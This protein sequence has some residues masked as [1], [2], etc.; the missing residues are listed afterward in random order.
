MDTRRF[1][2]FA[3]TPR[4]ARYAA[5]ALG[6][7]LLV[8]VAAAERPRELPAREHLAV[9]APADALQ[10]IAR[11]GKRLVAVGSKGLVLESIDGGQR[12]ER[13]E[14]PGRPPFIALTVCPDGRFLLLDFRSGLWGRSSRDAP[15]ERRPIQNDP[16]N[17]PAGARLL[18]L[19][20]GPTGDLWAVGEYSTVLR[21]DD[22]GNRWRRVFDDRSDR[23]LTAV[24]L[25]GVD[26]VRVVGEFGTFLATDDGGKEWRIGPSVEGD[27][28]PH[29]AAFAPDG[30]TWV[31]GNTGAV[32]RLDAGA[33]QWVQEETQFSGAVYGISRG[34]GAMVIVGAGGFA[35]RRQEGTPPRWKRLLASPRRGVAHDLRG[36]TR[37]AEGPL[38]A[39][40]SAGLVRLNASSADAGSS[41]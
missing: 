2:R 5:I 19:H 12:F 41:P 23:L 37:P 30:R 6:S 16:E 36:L 27:L 40:G 39:V 31:V 38:F 20:C 11:D 13:T 25:I 1:C 22:R 28:Y 15:W 3:R 21:S 10:A 33:E 14:L 24:G 4:G 29:A 18:D 7:V 17:R 8:T 35:S 9:A 34:E 26:R 32:F